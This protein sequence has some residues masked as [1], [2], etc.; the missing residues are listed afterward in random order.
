M[1]LMRLSCPATVQPLVKEIPGCF[2]A[3]L[4]PVIAWM[5]VCGVNKFACFHSRIII[6]SNLLGLQRPFMTLQ[7]RQAIAGL[8]RNERKKM[9]QCEMVGLRSRKGIDIGPYSMTGKY[10]CSHDS[11]IISTLKIRT[12]GQ[13]R[14]S[15][16]GSCW[17]F[18][19]L[20]SIGP[21]SLTP[22]AE[23]PEVSATRDQVWTVSKTEGKKQ[24]GTL[25]M[26][27]PGVS[28]HLLACWPRSHRL[29]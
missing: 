25:C 23:L 12:V 28:F 8:G 26:E 18:C 4:T 24:P 22:P 7:L 15:K 16:S 27:N 1:M 6:S 14:P 20:P 29:S 11:S 19:I 21:S 2:P 5:P 13:F 17:G 9:N 10:A 3:V